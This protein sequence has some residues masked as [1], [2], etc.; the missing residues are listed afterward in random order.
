M[1]VIRKRWG[2]AIGLVVVVA[3]LFFGPLA[4]EI[5]TRR[6]FTAAWRVTDDYLNRV[7][8]PVFGFVLIGV[9]LALYFLPTGI[10]YVRKHQNLLAVGIVNLALG[11]T[12]LGWIAAL[13]WAVMNTQT[14][15]PDLGPA[16]TSTGQLDDTRPCP[17]CAEPIQRAARRCKHCGSVVQPLA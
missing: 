6:H 5:Y 10:A 2:I 11:W 17:E 3:L 16:Q 9:L 15:N 4:Y 13:V 12:L 1:D 7:F 8:G 14:P